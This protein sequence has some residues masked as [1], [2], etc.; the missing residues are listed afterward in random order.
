MFLPAAMSA[1][2]AVATVILKRKPTTAQ[3]LLALM[4]AFLAAAAVML[5]IYFRGHSGVL[6]IYNYLFE[7]FSAL[8]PVLLYIGVCSL[9]EPRGVSR[10]QRLTLLV[11]MIFIAGLTL[12]AL[13]VGWRGYDEL[14]H[15]MV[16]GSYSYQEAGFS[17]RFLYLWNVWAYPLMLVV[18][19]SVLLILS[20]R[21]VWYYQKRFNSYYAD[22]LQVRHIDSRI[23]VVLSWLFLPLAVLSFWAVIMRPYYYKYWLI[24]LSMMLTVVQFFVGQFV[25]RVDYDAAYLAEYVRARS[26]GRAGQ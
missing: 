14:C 12:G 9:T 5:A 10:G 3:I 20:T 11:P 6:F 23:L 24:A 1:F 8:V 13:G 18:Y 19:G 7:C 26:D 25:Y 2:W 17:M 21:K 16:E 4:Q 22:G 15:S